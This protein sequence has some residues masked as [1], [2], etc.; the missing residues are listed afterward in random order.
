MNHAAPVRG[1]SDPPLGG[2]CHKRQPAWLWSIDGARILWANP[3]GARL[4]NAAH[5]AAAC[6]ED[7]RTGGWHRRR[8][9]RVGG[10]AAIERR[11]SGVRARARFGAATQCARYCGCARL[12][13]AD[14]GPAS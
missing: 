7:F 13:F 3:V 9:T 8:L 2:A 4:F 6:E 11:P 12:I 14:G 5:G 1:V 10:Q